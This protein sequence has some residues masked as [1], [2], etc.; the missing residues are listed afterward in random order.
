MCVGSAIRTD[1]RV[2]IQDR[3]APDRLSGHL[4]TGILVD[5]DL[6][7]VPNQAFDDRLDLEVLIFSTDVNEHSAIDVIDA[8]K[9]SLFNVRGRTL[10]STAKLLHHSTYAAQIGEVGSD[11]LGSALEDLDGDVW[12]ALLRLGAVPP[13]INAID[14]S[15]LATVTEVERAQRQPKRA[16]HE[17]GSYHDVPPIWCI[18]F[19]FCHPHDHG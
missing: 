19:C 12:E 2:S 6:V 11:A 15:W 1:I 8:W 5:G 13:G 7:L 18:F 16:V 10:A 17:L 4:A 14:P 9:W 3:R